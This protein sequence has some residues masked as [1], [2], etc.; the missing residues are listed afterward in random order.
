MQFLVLDM[1]LTVYKI[2]ELIEVNH[3]FNKKTIDESLYVW[4]TTSA[5]DPTK[6]LNAIASRIGICIGTSQS[7]SQMPNSSPSSW[8]R[9]T[10]ASRNRSSGL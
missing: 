2:T 8:W 1:G 10:S 3:T 5:D 7:T 6:P 9:H 4:Q